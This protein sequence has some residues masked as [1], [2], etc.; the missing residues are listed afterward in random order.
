[1]ISLNFYFDW[2]I[3]LMVMLQSWFAHYVP[4]FSIIT[5]FGGELLVI[6]LIVLLYFGYD[7]KLGK[8]IAIML[9]M[10]FIFNS[11]IK[12]VFIRRRPYFDH[13]SVKC[14]EEA[15][16]LGPANDLLAQGYSFPS[17][18]ATM[19]FIVF[20]TIALNTKKKIISVIA[21]IGIILV[22]LSR[23]VLGVHYP[24]D[25]LVGWALGFIILIAGSYIASK[26]ENIKLVYLVLLIIALLGLLFCNSSDYYVGLGL[27]IGFMAGFIFEEKYVNF[28]N[29]EKP[30]KIILRIIGAVIVFGVVYVIFKVIVPS[31]AP[32]YL[33]NLSKLIC[34][35][36][37]VFLTF[38]VYPLVFKKFQNRLNLDNA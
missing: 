23:V 27:L 14:F 37:G 1:M 13:S 10:C 33:V 2:E 34:F 16:P 30:L 31:S 9:S 21:V 38:G 20:G 11:M 22:G 15:S 36:L 26:I 18:H 25:V 32:A 19:S 17:A 7:K 5:H 8:S 6:L 12:N 24:T 3:S 4:I 35:A 29:T 28:E